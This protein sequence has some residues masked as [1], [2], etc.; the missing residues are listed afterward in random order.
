MTKS[1]GTCDTSSKVT[2]DLQRKVVDIII[3]YRE[4][5]GVKALAEAKDMID[6]IIDADYPELID[7]SDIPSPEQWKKD[8]SRDIFYQIGKKLGVPVKDMDSIV[9]TE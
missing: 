6:R 1:T 2:C 4:R 3:N 8:F 9:F 5:G 7:S